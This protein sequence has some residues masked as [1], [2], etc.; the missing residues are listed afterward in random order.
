MSSKIYIY[1]LKRVRTE[2]ILQR[3]LIYVSKI[4]I[5][6]FIKIIYI[7]FQV[8]AVYAAVLKHIWAG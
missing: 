3:L 4:H 1:S 5:E 8:V 2:R 6:I 7:P